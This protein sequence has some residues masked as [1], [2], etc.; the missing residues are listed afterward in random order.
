MTG[1][2]LEYFEVVEKYQ[3]YEEIITE[4]DCIK[5]T[6]ES[7]D[8][9]KL[10]SKV[11]DTKLLSDLMIDL[12][13]L[14]Y[15]IDKLITNCE[16]DKTKEVIN[17]MV[18][19]YSSTLVILNTIT[20][21]ITQLNNIL[22]FPELDC[23]NDDNIVRI[24]NEIEKNFKL[25]GMNNKFL[26]LPTTNDNLKFFYRYLNYP[27][28]RDCGSNITYWETKNIPK[29]TKDCLCDDTDL[30]STKLSNL[31]QNLEI[32]KSTLS[33]QIDSVTKMELG[34]LNN[35]QTTRNS[36]CSDII[37]KLLTK[38][39]KDLTEIKCLGRKKFK[40]SNCENLP[41]FLLNN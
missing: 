35:E 38:L 13:N 15:D 25:V 34:I 14:Q 32:F 20:D 4:L 26:K 7:E 23:D 27:V 2:N 30:R 22:E 10:L 33:S 19:I 37:S 28:K 24:M 11:K 40:D 9:C 36:Q 8:I 16:F 31:I 5:R 12:Y 3:V 6:A 39:G 17:E 41:D 18:D 1:E 29:L 21:L